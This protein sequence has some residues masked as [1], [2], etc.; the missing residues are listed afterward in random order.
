M[1]T[2]LRRLIAAVA[3]EGFVDKDAMVKT[4]KGAL[5]AGKLNEEQKEAAL[6]LLEA[7][8]VDVS[9]LKK[10]EKAA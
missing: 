1:A 9:A 7:F 5:N 2:D 4:L 6:T 8:G 10:G 3:A